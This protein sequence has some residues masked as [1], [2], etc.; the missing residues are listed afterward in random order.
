MAYV[1]N[2]DDLAFWREYVVLNRELTLHQRLILAG[3]SALIDRDTWTVKCTQL[4]LSERIAM[5]T[6]TLNQ[7]WKGAVEE[8]GLIETVGHFEY[9][10]KS[11][12]KVGPVFKLVMPRP[13]IPR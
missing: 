10:A 1:T 5:A 2:E 4:M 8:S 12:S 9:Q 13:E 3:L 7:H 11:R 6:S